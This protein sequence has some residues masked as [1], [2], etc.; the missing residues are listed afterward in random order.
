MKVLLLFVCGF[1][2]S[3]L[4]GRSFLLTNGMFPSLTWTLFALM[5][6]HSNGQTLRSRQIPFYLLT[7]RQSVSRRLL[8]SDVNYLPCRYSSTDTVTLAQEQ[9]STS[10]HEMFP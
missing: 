9:L 2:R 6:E 7:P 3:L 1:S 10:I 8:L 4:S 5:C